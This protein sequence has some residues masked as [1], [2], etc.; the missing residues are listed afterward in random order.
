MG[1]FDTIS[2]SDSLPYSQ[3]MVDLGLNKN[4]YVW[5]TQ[6]L[7]CYLGEYFIQGGKLFE[8]KYKTIKWI[9]GNKNSKD[10]LDKMGHM[11]REDP[12]LEQV[13]FHGEIYFYDH[14][15][16]VQDKWDCWIE[17]KAVFSNDMVD[18]YELVEFR[19]TDNAERKK[20]DKEFHDKIERKSKLWYNKYLFHTKCYRKFS[21]LWYKGCMAISNLFSKLAFKL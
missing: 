12:Y 7:E 6:D 19:K 18:R 9:E 3:E 10:V 5:Q 14:I 15:N 2:V 4:T 16:D 1:M 8:K 13:K 20:L 21:H 11:E 17:F